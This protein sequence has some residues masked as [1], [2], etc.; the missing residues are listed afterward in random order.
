MHQQR[1]RAPVTAT[2]Q[3]DERG[4]SDV[5]HVLL[6]GA[7]QKVVALGHTQITKCG[8]LGSANPRPGLLFGRLDNLL[9]T[10]SVMALAQG[11]RRCLAGARIAVAKGGKQG[12]PDGRVVDAGQFTGRE[13]AEHAVRSAGAEGQ[14]GSGRGRAADHAESL[15]GARLL[16]EAG[17]AIEGGAQ[18]FDSRGD[19]LRLARGCGC[20]HDKQIGTLCLRRTW[21]LRKGVPRGLGRRRLGAR[22]SI[23][24]AYAQRRRALSN[25]GQ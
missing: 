20:E 16:L 18:D 25:R 13:E 1:G 3:S 7:K 17:R 15:D 14:Q 10:R 23:A 19:L 4:H 8:H 22:G 2:S 12:R 5:E 11:Q 6:I 9:G 21:N 24:Q